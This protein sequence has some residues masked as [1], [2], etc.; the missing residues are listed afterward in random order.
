MDLFTYSITLVQFQFHP[1]SQHIDIIISS[2][3]FTIIDMQSCSIV[4]V[5]VH[6]NFSIMHIQVVEG[7]SDNPWSLMRHLINTI[8]L[9]MD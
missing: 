3:K 8:A 7:G 5:I 9:H 2:M 4:P 1:L 6:I